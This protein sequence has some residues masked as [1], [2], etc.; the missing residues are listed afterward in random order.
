[1]NAGNQN[2][3]P[4]TLAES[5]T[6]SRLLHEDRRALA[7]NG[8]SLARSRHAQEVEQIKRA[9]AANINNPHVSKLQGVGQTL[10]AT[11][12]MAKPQDP[13]KYMGVDKLASLLQQYQQGRDFY[14]KQTQAAIT[15]Q[16]SP[17]LNNGQYGSSSIPISAVSSGIGGMHTGMMGI[18]HDFSSH[19]EE[20][21]GQAAHAM[22]RYPSTDP[23]AYSRSIKYPQSFNHCVY[24]GN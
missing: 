24:F 11:M 16:P 14:V 7:H 1:M 5:R 21:V 2:F 19:A 8:A 4:H 18:G 13:L 10:P 12:G 23:L 15:G 9:A 17:L 20:S 22:M 6:D 3:Q